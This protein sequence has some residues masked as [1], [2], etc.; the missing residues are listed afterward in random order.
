MFTI[1]GDPLTTQHTPAG[2]DPDPETSE[3]TLR[4]WVRRWEIDGYGYWA[5]ARARTEGIIGFGGVERQTVRDRD[6]LNLYY[7]PTPGVWRQ[8]YATAL[9]QT[10]VGL[11]QAYLPPYRLPASSA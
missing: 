6:V 2:P 11:A 7:R 9:A 10:A 3:G 5:V 1:H 8:G 4:D